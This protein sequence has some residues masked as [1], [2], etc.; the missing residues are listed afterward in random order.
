MAYTEEASPETRPDSEIAERL[1]DFATDP[2]MTR[3]EGSALAIL[4][5]GTLHYTATPAVR[6][7]LPAPALRK[8]RGSPVDWYALGVLL[9]IFSA[10]IAC[11]SRIIWA[12]E[13]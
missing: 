6:T 13:P 8:R 7:D 5:E 2:T 1:P 10:A 12:V 3:P 9:L 4:P 11:I